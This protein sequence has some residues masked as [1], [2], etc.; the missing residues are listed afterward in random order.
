MGMV[1]SRIWE[2][3]QNVLE[4]EDELVRVER[5]GRVGREE[6]GERVSRGEGR[7]E[8]GEEERRKRNMI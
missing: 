6:R 5:G 1:T 4:E 8:R 2:W 7:G 3:S